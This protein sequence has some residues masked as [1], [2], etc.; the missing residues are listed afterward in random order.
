MTNRG[1][2]YPIISTSNKNQT[3][4]NEIKKFKKVFEIKGL[5]IFDTFTDEGIS[6]S[7]VREDRRRFNNL[8]K[9]QLKRT[10]TP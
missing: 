8:I 4:E 9:G 3:T 5:T 6:E 7:R 1:L 2:I 10:L